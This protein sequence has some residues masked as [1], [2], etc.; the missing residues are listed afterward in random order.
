M[1]LAFRGRERT[2][3][4]WIAMRSRPRG[5]TISTATFLHYCIAINTGSP[6]PAA[7]CTEYPTYVVT[8]MH[9]VESDHERHADCP[10]KAASRRGRRPLGR[11]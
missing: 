2:R 7:T 5:L 3:R 6:R 4:P 11:H 10:A 1:L 8:A 9:P